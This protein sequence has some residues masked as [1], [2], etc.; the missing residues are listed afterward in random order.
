M[1]K[2][3]VIGGGFAGISVI[4]DLRDV[5]DAEIILISNDTEFR[6]TP[7]LYH[8]ATGGLK[9]E[10]SMPV[11]DLISTTP[12]TK[13]ILAKADKIDRAKK[14]ISLD[15]GDT[16]HYD[17][18]VLALGVV[19]NYFGA[20]GLD[21][22]SYSIK[23][24]KEVEKLKQHLHEQ[25]IDDK[26]TDD[27]YVIVGAGPTGVE[28]GSALGAYIKKIARLHKVKKN[29]VTIEIVEAA[30]RILPS[31]SE[32]A[33]NIALKRLKQIGVK[34]S[35]KSRVKSET[36]EGLILEDRTI[37]TQTVVWT[38]GIS[39]NPFFQNN[40]DQF[41]LDKKNKVIVDDYMCVDK[42]VFVVGDNAATKFSGMAQT[43]IVQAKYVSHGIKRLLA[44]KEF[45]PFKQASPV[46][47]IPISPKQAII[48]WKNL[49]F[50]GYI[51]GALRSIADLIGYA[52]IMGYKKAFSLWTNSEHYE[53]NCSVCNAANIK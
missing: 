2:I 22:Y 49:S 42:F 41:I 52:D 4:R 31:L 30:D 10:S 1:K 18:C 16:I 43:A 6:Y 38:A 21:R 34:V 37:E 29:K 23:S 47:A 40:A 27:N 14:S 15:N 24:A 39:N 53:E 7:A 8:T 33:A 26:R 50:G 13:F 44:G 32:K 35:V 3:V 17:Y 5:E 20:E 11:Q 46:Y 48:T 51:G 9:R 36:Q 19:T 28:L 12:R 45:K 25:L